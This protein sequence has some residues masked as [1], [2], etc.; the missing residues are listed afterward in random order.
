MRFAREEIVLQP[1]TC[2]KAD[3]VAPLI[4]DTDPHLF[5]YFFGG[6]QELA[7]S[8]LAAQWRQERSL[9][10]YRY[11]TVATAHGSLL[12]D[13]AR[14]DPSGHLAGYGPVCGAD[15]DARTNGASA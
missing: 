5:E 11:G 15:S 7:V 9:F 8:Y 3:A 2:E 10:S 1:A 13:R 12:G 4:Y 6:D 14:Q